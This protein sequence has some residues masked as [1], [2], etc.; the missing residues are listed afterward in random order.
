ML[1]NHHPPKVVTLKGKR[2]VQSRTSGNKSQ[3]TVIACVS[4]TGHA[5]LP[6]VIFDVKGLNYKWTKGKVAETRYR[7]SSSRCV[8]TELFK[9]WLL[10]HFMKYA[11]GGRPLLS[12]LDGHSMHYQPELIKYARNHEIILFCLLP[13]T[14]HK[15]QPQDATVFKP[16]KLHCHEAFHCFV[17]KKPGKSVTKYHFLQLLNEAWDKTTIPNI[18]SSGFKRSRIYPFDP[19]AIDYGSA[20]I[21]SN[22]EEALMSPS[23]LHKVD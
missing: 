2:K 17:E 9:E 21:S 14:T 13:H 4:A 18:I 23:E 8:D 11:V 6:F 22:K 12:I 3:I 10:Q 20:E 16:L 19:D 15:S 1:L 5:L 7:L